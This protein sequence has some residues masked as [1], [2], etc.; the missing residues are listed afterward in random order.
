MFLLLLS[1]TSSTFAGS[2]TWQA[3]PT[4]GDWNTAANWTPPTVPNGQSDTA[5]FAASNTTG[6]SLSANTEVIGIA[7]NA[8]ASAFTITAGPTLTLTVSGAG[9]ANNSGVTQNFVTTSDINGTQHGTIQFRNGATAGN[10]THITDSGP[11]ASDNPGGITQFFDSSSAGNVGIDNTI[12]SGGGFGGGGTEFYDNSTAGNAG[13]FNRGG[14]TFIR[15]FENSTAGNGGFFNGGTVSFSDSSNAGNGTFFNNNGTVNRQP[16]AGSAQ[17]ADTSTAGN[18]TFTNAGGET[19]DGTPGSTGFAGNSSAGNG[20]FTC[21]PG[22]EGGDGGGVGFSQASTA[23]NATLIANGDSNGDGGGRIY[24]FN[25]SSGG[26]ARVKVFGNGFL[27]IGGHNAPGVSIGSIQ[28]S[29]LVFLGALNLTVGSNNRSTNFSGLI[30]DGRPNQTG[31]GGSLSKVGTGTLVLRNSNAYTGGTTINGGKLVVNN[32]SGSGTGSGPLQVNA[33]R[34]GGSGMIAGDVT[35]GDGSGRG[36][37]LSPGESARKRGTLTTQSTLT[38]KSDAIY[39]FNL[40]SD[41]AKSDSV[42]SN[43]VTIHSGAQFTFTDV[44]HGTLPIGTVFTVIDNTS[45]NSITGT[46]S[47]L[48][49]GSTFSSHGN[50]YQVNYEGGDGNDLTLTVVP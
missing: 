11:E 49:D 25:D 35:V 15:F 37:I 7:F 27:D 39:K 40:N 12:G 21:E 23:A 45:G 2:A 30:Q 29:G 22:N 46:F 20:T 48:P 5:T 28:G 32:E 4:S 43:G 19:S 17:F 42:V 33:G 31:S 50:T 38:L 47:N 3:N 44:A 1:I 26:Q 41:T 16:P 8:G 13:F 34:L 10:G 24:F 36:A 6:V 18:G 9:I 14:L